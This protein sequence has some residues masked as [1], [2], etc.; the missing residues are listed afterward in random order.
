MQIVN[1]DPVNAFIGG[2]I[3]G[4]SAMMLYILRGDVAGINGMV[5][6]ILK[7]IK[8]EVSWRV[9]FIVGLV[10]GGLIYR[11]YGGTITQLEPAVEG[12]WVVLAGLLV[13]LG[14]TFGSGCTSGHGI[15]GIARW[16][17]R[18]IAATGTFM[19]TAIITVFI[20]RHVL[21]A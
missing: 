20:I 14:A 17:V 3:L 21:G 1:F 10:L 6:G 19:L 5:T 18:S 4:G 11:S 8:G 12:Y 16:S 7:P 9:L 13:G 15:C 2:L